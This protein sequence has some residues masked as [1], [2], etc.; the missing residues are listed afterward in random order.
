MSPSS[1]SIPRVDSRRACLLQHTPCG[2]S[3]SKA[4]TFWELQ[5][6]ISTSELQVK[7]IQQPH[8]VGVRSISHKFLPLPTSIPTTAPQSL[9][10]KQAQDACGLST[11]RAAFTEFTP[12][13]VSLKSLLHK[14][15]RQCSPSGIFCAIS[16]CTAVTA[17]QTHWLLLDEHSFSSPAAQQ[18]CK[19]YGRSARS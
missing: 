17:I 16:P 1:V 2:L 11:S 8:K 4:P 3:P 9:P 14:V 18:H 7:D 15:P 10:R 5:A 12:L 6:H 13:F 19:K